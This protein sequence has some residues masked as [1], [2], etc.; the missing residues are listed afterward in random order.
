MKFR[1]KALIDAFQLIHRDGEWAVG[2][3]QW[4]TD[5]VVMGTVKTFMDGHVEINTL[6]GTMVAN[7]GD[8]IAR[9]VKG[10][11]YPIKDEIFRETY[12]EASEEVEANALAGATC[13]VN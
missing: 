12:E 8:W 4:F 9:G 5:A 1:K 6:E 2:A 11:L 13:S 10:E 3:P 7:P